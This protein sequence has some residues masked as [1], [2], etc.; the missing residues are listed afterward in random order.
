[1]R[2][3]EG[4]F[5]MQT[6][7]NLRKTFRRRLIRVSHQSLICSFAL[8]SLCGI[9]GIALLSE[10]VIAIPKRSDIEA[11]A[12]QFYEQQKT[13]PTKAAKD[14]QI[15]AQLSQILLQP[16]A[17]KLG[18]K[19]LL[20]VADGALQYIPFAALPLCKDGTCNE[21]SRLVTN[22]EIVNAPSISTIDIIRNSKRRT[23]TK[24]LAVIADP[25]FGTNDE[26]FTDIATKLNYP[27]RQLYA[28]HNW[29]YLRMQNIQIPIIGRDLHYKVSGNR[30]T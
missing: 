12:K 2:R 17:N 28:P 14:R 8:H 29:Q 7:N 6:T 16:V 9:V 10:S 23:P 18:N 25:V 15:G 22:H 5:N 19:R 3:E 21:S 24:T 1:M 11:Q 4:F 27:L 30:R 26:R 13:D 20:I